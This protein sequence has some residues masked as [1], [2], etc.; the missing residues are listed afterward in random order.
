MVYNYTFAQ[1]RPFL[2]SLRQTGY[3][4][5]IVFFYQ[6]IDARAREAMREMGVV[7]LPF[8]NLRGTFRTPGAC[9]FLNRLSQ[10]YYQRKAPFYSIGWR[11]L[12]SPMKQRHLLFQDYLR[13]NGSRF[14]RVLITDTRDVFFQRDPFSIDDE[15]DLAFFEESHPLA[16]GMFNPLWLL[17]HFGQPTLQR[18]GGMTALCAGTIAGRPEALSC[19]LERMA[20]L[21][22]EADRMDF[23]TGDQSLHNVLVRERLANIPY[24]VTLFRNGQGPVYTLSRYLDTAEIPLDPDGEVIN[25][26]G[27]VIPI[28]HQ[29]DR[30]PSIMRGLLERMERRCQVP[31]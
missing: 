24:R 21:M 11:W 28:L 15:S 8:Y 12:L 2:L 31:S 17:Y 6:R 27:Q 19:Y 22:Q 18:L 14:A 10:S 20:T 3:A 30:H 25:P 4:G 16:H 5:E 23:A 9:R 7:L 26:L 1:V 13:K 29:Y